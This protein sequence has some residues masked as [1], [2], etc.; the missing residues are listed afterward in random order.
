MRFGGGGVKGLD[1]V[2]IYRFRDGVGW[3]GMFLEMKL[4]LFYFRVVI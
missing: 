3:D 1:V 4:Y 2:M